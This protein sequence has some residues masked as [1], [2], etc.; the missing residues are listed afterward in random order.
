VGLTTGLA[1]LFAS[2]LG[3]AAWVLPLGAWIWIVFDHGLFNYVADVGRLSG[4]MKFIYTLDGY[5]KL[6]SVALYLLLLGTLFFERWLLWRYRGRTN[7]HAEHGQPETAQ[8]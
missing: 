4:I 7:L 2:R 5:G 6:S 1:R 8:G 3:K